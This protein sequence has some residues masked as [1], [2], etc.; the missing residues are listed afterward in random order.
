MIEQDGGRLQ[1]SSRF[2]SM[3]K[4]IASLDDFLARVALLLVVRCLLL[5]Q[6]SATLL[7]IQHSTNERKLDY[8]TNIRDKVFPARPFFLLKAWLALA[9]Y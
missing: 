7:Y 2:T 4:N 9:P 5:P 3:T 8:K 6:P 1:A